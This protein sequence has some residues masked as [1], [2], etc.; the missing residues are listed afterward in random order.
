MVVSAVVLRDEQHGVCHVRKA[1]TRAFM[2]P[3]GKPEPGETATE[4]AVREVSEELGLHLSVEDLQDWGAFSTAAANEPNT[5]LRSRVF[6]V[7]RQ[8]W[9]H[10]NL[11][12]HAEIDE[13]RWIPVAGEDPPLPEGTFLADLAVQIR[14]LMQQSSHR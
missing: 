5:I 4:T 8:I 14:H 13:L 9:Q 12:P 7:D 2:F 10:Q 6:S 1:G 3:G 11:Q